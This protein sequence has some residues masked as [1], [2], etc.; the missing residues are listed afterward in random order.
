MPTEVTVVGGGAI[1]MATAYFLR[2]AGAEVRVLEGSM[3][4]SG[5]SRANS[6][7]ISPFFA[8]PLAAAGV[9]R[10]V[11]SS[12]GRR[13]SPLYIAPRPD[14]GLLIWACRFLARCNDEDFVHGMHQVARL[15]MRTHELYDQLATAGINFGVTRSDVLMVGRHGDSLA[16]D[17]R[18]LHLLA[19]YGYQ[20]PPGLLN[21]ADLREIEPF[22][23]TKVKAG[24]LI[25][26]EGFVD[27]AEVPRGFAEA[28]V[29]SGGEI[30]ERARVTAFDHARGR[31]TRVRTTRGSWSVDR[32]VIA[33][34]AWSGRLAAMLGFRLPIQAGKGYSFSI[35]PEHPPRKP[36]HF[37]E[38]KAVITPL[39]GRTRVSGTMELSGLN[40]RLDRR[41]ISA[42]EAGARPYVARWPEQ[43][44]EDEWVGLRPISADGLP[45]LGA[46][47]GMSN[48]FMATGH[49]MS[50]ITLA[51]AT[52]LAMSELVLG[53]SAAS[54]L[55]P[56]DPARFLR[57]RSRAGV[58]KHRD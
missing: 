24:F 50:G 23:S 22:L 12:F 51:P 13:N 11:L 42:I 43:D 52:G 1:G 39:P 28:L 58:L 27:P 26:G 35:R 7:W 44:R 21:G 18:R 5:A 40:S 53:R 45:V 33:A 16:A 38:S 48:A 2:S 25:E 9:G 19:E 10:T 3:V 30:V 4:G 17:L 34:G 15:G 56:F 32:V 8:G 36:I 54:A 20:P 49:S 29:R 46:V 57:R 47:P 41:R 37:G 6:G 55:A 31:V 14:P